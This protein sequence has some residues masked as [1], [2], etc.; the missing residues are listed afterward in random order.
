[1]KTANVIIDKI[2]IVSQSMAQSYCIF[3]TTKII[4]IYMDA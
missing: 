1:M 4:S 3:N 2:Q